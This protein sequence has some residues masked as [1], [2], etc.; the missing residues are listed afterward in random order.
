[1]PFIAPTFSG[2]F[3]RYRSALLLR[4]SGGSYLA[5]LLAAAS[6][7]RNG[8]RIFTISE[9]STAHALTDSLLDYTLR[10]NEKIVAS[11]HEHMITRIG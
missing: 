5:A 3:F 7:T 2:C 10:V 11:C 8:G 4:G 6:T 9:W 1:M